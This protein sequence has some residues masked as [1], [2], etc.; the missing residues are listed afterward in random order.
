MNRPYKLG[1]VTSHPIQ[2]QAPLFRALANSGH[3]HPTVLFC[4]EWGVNVY[5]DPQFGTEFRW[6]IPLLD[7]YDHKFL[8]N[9][10]TAS[11]PEGY[12]SLLNPAVATDIRRSRFDAVM[13][14]GWGLATMWI[15]WAA[16]RLFRVPLLLRG[17][18]N[19]LN[20]PGGANPHLRDA[21]LRPYLNGISGFLAIGACN[22]RF[23]RE[24][25]IPESRI[26][27]CPYTVDNQW[28]IHRCSERA[29]ATSDLRRRLGLPRHLP[30]VLFCG[31][32]IPKKRPME[33]LRAFESTTQEKE[34]AL[35]YVG[36]GMLR[37]ELERY[38]ADRHVRN[39]IFAGFRNQTELP[40]FYASA[41]VF[42][43]PSS[44]EPWGLVV[45]EAMCFGLPVIAS[46]QV[47]SAYDLVHEGVNGFVYP[48]GDIAA[49]SAGLGSLL[50]DAAL[51]RR[52]GAESRGLIRNWGIDQAVDGMSQALSAICR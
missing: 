7:G 27:N 16:A 41:D 46:D 13:I 32:L 3:I 51:R 30:I 44:H 34:A 36:D 33:L 40:D 19:G 17:E 14:H 42:V 28:F 25:G 29:G 5:R 24:L 23:Y 6:D 38:V 21:I 11:G 9:I 45:N 39:V 43:L 37:P 15:A 49:L 48:T 35:V 50:R 2:Y 31:K 26:F 47:G 52:M 10:G 8:G 20:R 22:R 4:S 12:F 1:I 18:S